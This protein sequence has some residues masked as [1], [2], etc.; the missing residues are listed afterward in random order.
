MACMNSNYLFVTNV[1]EEIFEIRSLVENLV[2]D[3]KSQH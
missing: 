3:V 2:N 1:T